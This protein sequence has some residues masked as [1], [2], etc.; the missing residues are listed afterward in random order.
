MSSAH[1]PEDRDTGFLNRTDLKLMA[2][3]VVVLAVLG[4]GRLL[5]TAIASARRAP[6]PPTTPAAAPVREAAPVAA[7]TRDVVLVVR[8]AR[9]QP[10]KANGKRWDAPGRFELPDLYVTVRNLTTGE[11][12]RSAVRNDTLFAQFDVPAVRVKEGDLLHVRVMDKDIRFD[13]LVGEQT[14]RV[15]REMLAQRELDWSFGQVKSLRLE[16]RP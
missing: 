12:F 16:L 14:V 10:T 8:S 11:F 1:A 3:A 13:D 2:L 7:G 5:S 9:A 6:V 4:V 15:T